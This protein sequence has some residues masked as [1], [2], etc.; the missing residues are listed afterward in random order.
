MIEG[1]FLIIA[2]AFFVDIAARDGVGI[3][4]VIRGNKVSREE[5]KY[6]ITRELLDEIDALREEQICDDLSLEEKEVLKEKIQDRLHILNK[7]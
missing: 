6:A 4:M 7:L 2:A 1:A 5:S 3:S